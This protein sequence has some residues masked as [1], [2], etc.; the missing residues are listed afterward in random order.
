MNKSDLGDAEKLPL[1][2]RCS[3]P[4]VMELIE[5]SCILYVNGDVGVV[6]M[7][8]RGQRGATHGLGEKVG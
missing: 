7:K 6:W 8:R 4:N 3:G 1:A 5:N 2:R